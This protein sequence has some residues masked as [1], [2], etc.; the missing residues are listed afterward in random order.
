MS[1]VLVSRTGLDG[2]HAAFAVI[3][4]IAVLGAFTA[5]IGFPRS[6]VPEGQPAFE[7]QPPVATQPPRPIPVPADQHCER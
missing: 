6:A 4:I 2:F 3:G 1:T 5:A 7:I